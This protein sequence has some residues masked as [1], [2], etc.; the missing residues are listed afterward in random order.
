MEA[1]QFE[2][3]LHAA[4]SDTSSRAPDQRNCFFVLT[5]IVSYRTME[6]DDGEKVKRIEVRRREMKQ[7][8]L[9]LTYNVWFHQGFHRPPP[10]RKTPTSGRKKEQLII[11]TTENFFE[12]RTQGL[13]KEIKR[14]DADVICL[15]EVTHWSKDIIVGDKD[16]SDEYE[17]RFD[18]L[19]RYGTAILIKKKIFVEESFC[20]T[21]IPTRMGRTL[22]HCMVRT[23]AGLVHV[24]TAHFESL[25]SKDIRRKQ[26]AKASEV[27]KSCASCVAHVIC[28]DFNF[29]S[30]RNYSGTGP[31]ENEVLKRELPNFTD[32]WPMLYPEK[33]GYTF[34]S[35]SNRNIGKYERMRYDRVLLANAR[36]ETP[37]LVPL[38]MRLIGTDPVPGLD[39]QP[40]DHYGLLV[41]MKIRDADE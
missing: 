29:C 40:S 3:T 20:V 38:T 39:R 10:P 23:V 33:K 17:L 27:A 8:L 15:Q 36:S 13:L 16:L 12:E 6:D 34:D 25:S 1:S 2:R 30:Y 31:L 26:L 4:V 35:T 7:T 14:Y 19:G 22:L 18:V 21:E 9:V 37:A 28:G 24:A 5:R 41:T 32:V 11:D